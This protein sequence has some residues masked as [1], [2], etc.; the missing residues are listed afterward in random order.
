[1]ESQDPAREMEMTMTSGSVE[2]DAA[3]APFDLDV[4]L[5]TVLGLLE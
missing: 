5:L 2:S 3:A 1:M 4:G